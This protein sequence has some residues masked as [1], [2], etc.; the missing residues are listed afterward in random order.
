M[1]AAVRAC[2]TPSVAV[3]F[4]GGGHFAYVTRVAEY[5]AL[6]EQVLSLIS[7]GPDWGT[8]PERCL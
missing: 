8:D 7:T 4:L 6:L 3:R 2:Q 5:A 1:L